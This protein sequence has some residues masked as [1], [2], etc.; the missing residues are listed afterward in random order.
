MEERRSERER[1]REREREEGEREERRGREKKKEERSP[2]LFPLL[3]VPPAVHTHLRAGGRLGR[4]AGRQ[5]A[6]LPLPRRATRCRHSSCKREKRGGRKQTQL[7][8][9]TKVHFPLTL[10]R[11]LSASSS[12]ASRAA[13]LAAHSAEHRERALCRP[14]LPFHQRRALSRSPLARLPF[15]LS[16]SPSLSPPPSGPRSPT[17][18]ASRSERRAQTQHGDNG[19]REEQRRIRVAGFVALARQGATTRT[20]TARTRTTTARTTAITTATTTG[21]TAS[22]ATTR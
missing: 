20:T 21:T 10:S 22:A 2:R 11:S 19:R 9:G 5:G 4:P 13:H 18:C 1:E 6:A 16:L 3:L 15:S 14:T 17:T 8:L 7:C 12:A